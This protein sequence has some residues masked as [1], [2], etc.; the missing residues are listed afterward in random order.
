MEWEIGTAIDHYILFRDSSDPA[1]IDYAE[2]YRRRDWLTGDNASYVW[3]RAGELTLLQA[4]VVQKK[5]NAVFEGRFVK[6][7]KSSSVQPDETGEI[8]FIPHSPSALD[9]LADLLPNHDCHV[10]LV[11]DRDFFVGISSERKS[12]ERVPLHQPIKIY[13]KTAKETQRIIGGLDSRLSQGISDFSFAYRQDRLDI[14]QKDR[15]FVRLLPI[16]TLINIWQRV[17]C[18]PEMDVLRHTAIV[19]FHD[20]L[21]NDNFHSSGTACGPK[22]TDLIFKSCIEDRLSQVTLRQRDVLNECVDIVNSV[23]KADGCE[24]KNIVVPELVPQPASE[25]QGIAIENALDAPSEPPSRAVPKGKPAVKGKRLKPAPTKGRVN[26]ALWELAR[27]DTKA[28]TEYSAKRLAEL[29]GSRKK[30]PIKCTDSAVKATDFWRQAQMGRKKK[31]H[32]WENPGQIPDNQLG[33]DKE[34]LS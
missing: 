15:S 6:E 14:P 18:D 12:L 22:E 3:V 25:V 2:R 30:N 34:V 1:S 19:W 11:P 7:C 9:F 28:A 21:C 17:G 26:D 10:R 32:S 33:D 5:L 27:K 23:R 16:S 4:E 24:D 20:E 31:A 29:L 8:D 13:P